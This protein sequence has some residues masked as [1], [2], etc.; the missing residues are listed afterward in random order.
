MNPKPKSLI[1]GEVTKTPAKKVYIGEVCVC[2]CYL[3]LEGEKKKSL[4]FCQLVGKG[5]ALFM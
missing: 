3:E 2:G 5:I 4:S 1:L